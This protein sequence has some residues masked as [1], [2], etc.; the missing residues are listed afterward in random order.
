[1]ISSD[2][3]HCSRELHQRHRKH[4]HGSCQSKRLEQQPRRAIDEHNVGDDI[5]INI[6]ICAECPDEIGYGVVNLG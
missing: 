5:R 3:Y 1:L 2:S 4:R 6:E